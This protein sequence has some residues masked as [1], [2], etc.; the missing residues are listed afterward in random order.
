MHAYVFYETL[1]VKPWQS[2]N[3]GARVCFG[4]CN[5]VRIDWNRCWFSPNKR[6][7]KQVAELSSMV[8]RHNPIFR[9]H[10]KWRSVAHRLQFARSATSFPCSIRI[11]PT[12]RSSVRPPNRKVCRVKS[13]S[14]DRNWWK[15]DCLSGSRSLSVVQFSAWWICCYLSCSNDRPHSVI[16]RWVHREMKLMAQVDV[17]KTFITVQTSP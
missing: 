17:S 7:V 4:D 6:G 14:I 8:D 10:M 12:Q 3:L 5:S 11:S 2:I 16:G 13:V 9:P 1:N 15:A